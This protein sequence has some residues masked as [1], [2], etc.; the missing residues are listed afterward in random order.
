ML[1]CVQKF[2]FDY[3][4]FVSI[5]IMHVN[6]DLFLC[7]GMHGQL[8]SAEPAALIWAGSSQQ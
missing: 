8:L 7:L 2:V 3:Y 4:I 1:L 6:F 5:Q